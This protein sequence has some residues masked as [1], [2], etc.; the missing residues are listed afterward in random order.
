MPIVKK[1]QTMKTEHRIVKSDVM[2]YYN[3][4][5]TNEMDN[6]SRLTNTGIILFFRNQPVNAVISMGGPFFIGLDLMPVA[7]GF[8]KK[9]FTLGIWIRSGEHNEDETPIGLIKHVNGTYSDIY[10]FLKYI[11]SSYNEK[12]TITDEEYTMNIDP[13]SK[14]L[15]YTESGYD[16]TGQ[17]IDG[18]WR[19]Y[20]VPMIEKNMRHE[21]INIRKIRIPEDVD[22]VFESDHL[23]DG[24]VVEPDPYYDRL[25]DDEYHIFGQLVP[26]GGIIHYF[27]IDAWRDYTGFSCRSGIKIYLSKSKKNIEEYAMT[28]PSIASESE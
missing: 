16:L 23:F 6:F 8:L 25:G 10:E 28:Q 11:V 24:K 15:F 17:L 5:W 9:E 3:N 13:L 7:K 26:I 12:Y 1:A 4:I 19:E 18:K 14:E 2:E 22:T 21:K 27:Y 20:Y